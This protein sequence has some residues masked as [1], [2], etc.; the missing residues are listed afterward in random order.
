MQSGGNRTNQS[1]ESAVSRKKAGRGIRI[2][3]VLL[4]V[5]MAVTAG[6]LVVWRGFVLKTVEVVGNVIYSDEQIED[7]IFS[8]EDSWNTMYVFLRYRFQRQEELPFV[9]SIKV[10]ML[11]PSK[12]EVDVEE[13]GMLGYLYIPSLG[14]NAYFDQ[15]GFVVELTNDVIAG[16]TKITGLEVEDAALYEKLDLGENGLWKTMLTLTQ[17]LDKYDLSPETIY[18]QDETILLSYGDIQV[19][20]GDDTQLNEKILRLQQILPELAGMTGTLH[21]DNWSESSSD[22]HFKPDELTEIPVD[23]QTVVRDAANVWE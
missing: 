7:W 3:I 9:D 15:D 4:I 11:S 12:L 8:E 22:I 19:D 5:A 2:L 17:L 13:K 1:T 18:L 6:A 20:L 10:R 16:V 14:E 23:R 21:L